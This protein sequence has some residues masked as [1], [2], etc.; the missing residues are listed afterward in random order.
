MQLL[1]SEDVQFELWSKSSDLSFPRNTYLPCFKYKSYQIKK[2]LTEKQLLNILLLI[3]FVP[4]LQYPHGLAIPQEEEG[5]D[6]RQAN[7][8]ITHHSFINY[9]SYKYNYLQRFRDFRLLQVPPFYDFWPS[10]VKKL[11]KM[12]YS[13][14]EGTVLRRLLHVSFR[15]SWWQ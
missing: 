8:R 11:M 4:H 10:K 14:E 6:W 9:Q 12:N 1:K 7:T 5:N 3:F 13:W 15:P 2:D